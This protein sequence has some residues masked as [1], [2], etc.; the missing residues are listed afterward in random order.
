MRFEE[1]MRIYTKLSHFGNDG[2]R[3][4]TVLCEIVRVSVAT[5]SLYVRVVK[6]GNYLSIPFNAVATV[7]TPAK[8]NVSLTDLQARFNESRLG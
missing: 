4:G 8:V 6:N 3:K 7:I 1:G 2:S 5:K